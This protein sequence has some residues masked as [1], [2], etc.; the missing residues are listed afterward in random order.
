MSAERRI[1]L[2]Y[3]AT[4][5]VDQV[6]LRATQPYFSKKFGNAGSLHSFGQEVV[7]ALDASRETIASLLGVGF[8]EIVF[9]SSATEANNLALGGAVEKWRRVHRGARKP[10]IIISAIEHESVSETA[11]LL[12]KE[13]VDV[14]ILPVDA[15]G[16]AE[17]G[18]LKELLNN[19]T[20][21]VSIMYAN[22]ETGVIQPIAQLAEIVREFR[23]SHGD[24]RWPVFHTDAVQAFQFLDC[25]P[26]SLGVDLMTISSHKIYGPKGAGALYVKGSGFTLQNN[27]ILIPATT[28]GGQEFGL[29]SGTE[30]IPAIVGFSKAATL[31]FG[32]RGASSRRI[33]TLRAELLRGIKKICRGAEMN[34]G[35]PALPNI[36]NV[37][38]PVREAQDLLTR[39]DRMGLAASSGSACRARA[40]QASSVLGAMGCSHERS[41]SSIRFSLG[42]PTTKTEIIRALAVIKK[43]LV[44]K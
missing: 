3:A 17:G 29:R 4:T 23:E 6:V 33:A 42:R 21:I 5:P 36:L 43:A 44:Q 15:S 22:N 14:A 31:V 40:H 10:R 26:L 28:G 9:T 30:N 25:N 12:E 34:G 18:R 2:D 11:R 20:V 1:Y 38:F 8:Q 19:E 7:S 39:F 27:D 35:G 13:G 37:Y 16:V 41:R 32:S 24:P